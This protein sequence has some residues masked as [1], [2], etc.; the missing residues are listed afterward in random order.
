VTRVAGIVWRHSTIEA[1]DQICCL[2]G[3]RWLAP[4]ESRHYARLRDPQRRR[5]WLA[6]RVLCKRLLAESVPEVA[7]DPR[8]AE[9]Y[10][11]DTLGRGMRPSVV[12]DGGVLPWHLSISH[13]EIAVM[14][15]LS[16]TPG[17]TV[18]ADL[19]RVQ[20]PPAGWMRVWFDREEQELA[21]RGGPST[22]SVLWA[23]KE[24]VY[25]ACNHGEAFAPR[26]FRVR[27]LP[28]GY[29]CYYRNV[30]L[31]DGCAIQTWHL[32]SHVAALAVAGRAPPE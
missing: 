32:G 20:P 28:G 17:E 29:A 5:G 6:G 2:E 23:V 16:A 10:S 1:I 14:V 8:R 26:Q 15:A 19:V 27:R 9:I 7:V 30:D 21:D 3:D 12:I 25:K 13:T 18:G 11:Q 24:A 22:A 31:S 4:G